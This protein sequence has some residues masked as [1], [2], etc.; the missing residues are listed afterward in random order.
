MGEREKGAGAEKDR[1]LAVRVN[2]AHQREL[3]ASPAALP[4]FLTVRRAGHRGRGSA[5]SKNGKSPRSEAHV[6][7]VKRK[8]C[9][10]VSFFHRVAM[11][12]GHKTAPQSQ[13][14]ER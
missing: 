9:A 8:M 10:L 2:R 6:S 1:Q 11:E 7:F 13:P 12:P 5:R 4:P 3:R 14:P